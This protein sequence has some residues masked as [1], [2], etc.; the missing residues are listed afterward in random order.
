[1]AELA[2]VEPP[3]ANGSADAARAAASAAAARRPAVAAEL[4]RGVSTDMLLRT[5]AQGPNKQDDKGARARS[6]IHHL[7]RVYESSSD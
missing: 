6:M 2:V 7:R 1:M 4:A 5:R 3:A